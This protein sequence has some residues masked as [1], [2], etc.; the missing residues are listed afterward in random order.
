MYKISNDSH[1]ETNKTMVIGLLISLFTLFIG[2]F[3]VI[4]IASLVMFL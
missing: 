3:F 2:I 1:E 4:G